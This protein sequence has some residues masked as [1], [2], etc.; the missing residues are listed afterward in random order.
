MDALLEK[1]LLGGSPLAVLL[2]IVVLFLKDRRSDSDAMRIWL[3]TLMKDHDSQLT[4]ITK[5][6]IEERKLARESIDRMVAIS[7]QNISATN[8]NTFT[9]EALAREINNLTKK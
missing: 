3:Q 4:G 1:I 5:E 9:L 6:S 8:R 7:E 2:M